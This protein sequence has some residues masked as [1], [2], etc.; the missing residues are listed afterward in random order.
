M[1]GLTI[2]ATCEKITLPKT[3]K[4]DIIKI[5]QGL[6]FLF[7]IWIISALAPAKMK[8]TKFVPCATIWLKFIHS[9][10]KIMKSP[11]PPTPIPIRID[12]KKAT[13]PTNISSPQY[14]IK[15]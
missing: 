11:P 2:F 5:C 9:V 12:T 4:E 14:H 3:P 7:L 6:S 15:S 13:T 10:K 8:N 1:L